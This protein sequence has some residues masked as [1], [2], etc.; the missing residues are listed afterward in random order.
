VD[1]VTVKRAYEARD[2]LI[3]ALDYADLSTALRAVETL[4]PEVGYF[5]IGLE[6]YSAEG[7]A[8]VREVKA[9]GAK[10]FLDLKLHDIPNT[11][12]RATAVLAD[13]G[14]DLLNVHCAGGRAMLRAAAEAAA[15]S[16]TRVIAV[17]VL[18]SLD[19]ASLEELGI[20]GPLAGVARSWCGLAL[21][22]GLSGVVCSA[23]EAPGLRDAF[24]EAPLLV[25]PG[26]RPAGED[27]QDHSR[28]VTPGA[29]LR[30]GASHIV[31]GRPITAARDP[32][33]AAR[34]I[35]T[36]MEGACL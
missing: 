34:A 14:V 1:L 28:A 32:R 30:A 9:T 5:K 35:I 26:I 10:V 20:S 24:G 27:H 13:L 36:E 23:R 12:G 17:T 18:T 6:L 31:V 3:V 19:Q 7:P 21:D 11:V 2:R 8:A 4:L 25:T 22:C 29:A 33:A 15:G 16:R